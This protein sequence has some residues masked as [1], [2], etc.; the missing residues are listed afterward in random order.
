M[1]MILNNSPSSYITHLCAYHDSK[2]TYTLEVTHA[3]QPKATM[4]QNRAVTDT[5]PSEIVYN[6]VVRAEYYRKH[7][8]ISNDTRGM[9]G[10]I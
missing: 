5:L 4:R 9:Q 2:G 6:N 1:S 10:N 7:I 3:K 8:S